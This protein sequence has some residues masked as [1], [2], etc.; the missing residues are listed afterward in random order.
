MTWMDVL[1]LA[2]TGAMLGAFAKWVLQLDIQ[3]H[4]AVGLGILAL[5]LQPWFDT[6][7]LSQ[8]QSLDV[9]ATLAGGGLAAGAA[10]A[11]MLLRRRA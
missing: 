10:G 7:I 8:L 3:L 2:C 4:W 5:L 6:A 1:D 11:V 9:R